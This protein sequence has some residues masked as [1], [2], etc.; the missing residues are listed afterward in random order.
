MAQ[1]IKN[2][3]RLAAQQDFTS[4]ITLTTLTG[5]TIP[6]AANQIIHVRYCLFISIGATGGIRVQVT[7]PAGFVTYRHGLII[8]IT[9]GVT[10]TGMVVA[11]SPHTSALA[12][13]GNHYLLGEADIAN[14]ATAGDFNLQAAQNTSDALT[15]SILA[16]SWLETVLL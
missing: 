11:Q 1:G 2:V 8:G 14:G 4:N 6:L 3:F 10:S 15:L 7:V 5:L 9:G 13:A 16:G 12:T